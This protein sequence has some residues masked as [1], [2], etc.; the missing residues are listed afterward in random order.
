MDPGDVRHCTRRRA[1]GTQGVLLLS[2]ESSE[3][4]QIWVDSEPGQEATFKLYLRR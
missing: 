3:R 1:A 4:G 2:R